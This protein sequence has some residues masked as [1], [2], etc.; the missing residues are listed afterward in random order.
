MQTR[1][2]ITKGQQGACV[3]HGRRGDELMTC[4]MADGSRDCGDIIALDH[5]PEVE[6]AVRR[7]IATG[8]PET[9]TLGQPSARREDMAVY[10][11]RRARM[12][13]WERTDI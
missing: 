9:L 13:Q 3:T 12:A 6:E 1:Y 7:V 5:L 2:Q 10:E 8:Q 4:Y 11:A